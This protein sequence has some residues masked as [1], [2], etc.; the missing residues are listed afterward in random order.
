MKKTSVFPWTRV[1]TDWLTQS[2]KNHPEWSNVTRYKQMKMVLPNMPH[3][4]KATASKT[5][6]LRPSSSKTKWT[7]TTLEALA[8]L[9]TY[10]VPRS[11]MAT[12]FNVTESAITHQL[13]R[14][15]N[16]G[17]LKATPGRQID[18]HE[19]TTKPLSLC[20]RPTE[21]VKQLNIDFNQRDAN[22][23]AVTE[24]SIAAHNKLSSSIRAIDLSVENLMSK[25]RTATEMRTTLAEAEQQWG[26]LH[27]S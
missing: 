21:Q 2:I 8:Q 22:T 27:K 9:V 12:Y 18:A 11:E 23:K 3:T 10:E 26:A 15:K 4:R 17:L 25:P 7:I 1:E 24:A 5:N 6:T 13:H 16:L 19:R 20:I 14:I